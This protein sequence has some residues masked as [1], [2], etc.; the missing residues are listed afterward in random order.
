VTAVLWALVWLCIAV[1]LVYL[2][3]W[4]FAK[5]GIDIPPNVVMIIKVILILLALIFIID[6]FF[7]GGGQGIGIRP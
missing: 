5:L 4:V 3:L 2:I 7:I 6:H 1:A